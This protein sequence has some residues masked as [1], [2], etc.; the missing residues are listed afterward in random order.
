M[1][2][3]VAIALTASLAACACALVGVFLV[4][5]RMAMMAD[6]ISHAILPGLVAGYALAKG[7]N[8][9]AGFLGATAAGLL[10]VWLVEAL[11]RSRRVKEDTAIGLI[12]PALFALGVLIISKYFANVHLDTDA[13]LYGEIGLVTLERW[14][15]R[16][17]DL[18]PTA[19]WTLGALTVLNAVF[20]TLF[21]KELKLSTFDPGLAAALGFAPALL[22]YALMGMVAVTT[23]GGFTA[24]GAI[25]VIALIIVPPVTA[26]LMTHRLPTL[27]GLSVAVGVGGAL[28]GF[29]LSKVWDVSISGMIATV[30]GALFGAT[31]LFAPKQGLIAKA[32]RRRRQGWD[33][34][35]QMLVVHLASHEGTVAEDRECR[36]EHLVSE[37]G[38]STAEAQ[39][40]VRRARA[41]G[42]VDPVDAEGHIHLTERGKELAAQTA[43]IGM[44]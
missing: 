9:L 36:P 28:L 27:I 26:S 6:A 32:L 37:L 29:F 33:F 34:R 23:V 22:H 18:G 2:S 21:Y 30:Q 24:V 16:E 4:L 31:L 42:L 13:V 14:I 19:I 39:E 3:D 10:T 40:I 38:W 25:L 15:V 7:P 1:S 41:N 43:Q 11:T 44:T 12:F 17:I 35:Q 5:R 8:L 20:L